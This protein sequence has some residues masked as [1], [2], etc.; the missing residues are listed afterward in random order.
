VGGG[1]SSLGARLADQ[2][3]TITVVDISQRAID[4]ARD[5]LGTGGNKIRWIVADITASPELG[6]FD[7][8]HDRA[9]FH[10]LTTPAERM[11]YVTLLE[12][13]VRRGG[14]AIIAT[15]APDGPERCS[16]LE[17]RRYDGRGLAAE[18]GSQFNLVKSVP[19]RHATP[20]GQTQ[21][22]QYSVFGRR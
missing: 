6:T 8:W 10:F 7:V 9:V 16:G 2:G 12:K 1:T 19:E 14:F 17:V 18:L 20:W 22:F 13:T 21:S 4:R 5:R 11:A 3:Y 15:F